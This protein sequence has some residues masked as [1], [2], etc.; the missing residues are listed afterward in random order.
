MLPRVPPPR[1]PASIVGTSETMMSLR[2]IPAALAPVAGRLFGIASGYAA[3][4]TYYR[5]S[6]RD[7]LLCNVGANLPC[8]KANQNTELRAASDWC[9]DNRNATVIPMAVTGHDTIYAWRCIGGVGKA[10]RSN[11]Q[12]RSA[13]F[14]RPILE[15]SEVED[16]G[17]K[18]RDIRMCHGWHGSNR[19]QRRR[20]V[21]RGDELRPHHF[22]GL[23]ESPSMD[24]AA[25]CTNGR[26][27]SATTLICARIFCFFSG[28]RSD[29]GSAS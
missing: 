2:P 24:A 17:S 18:L 27:R 9:R 28:G 3:K 8:G 14:L 23:V 21:T 1:H 26:Q 13:R 12:G 5:C 11:R 16:L 6:G 15:K 7:L 20:P 29:F 25:S 4:T 19:W 22:G 10:D